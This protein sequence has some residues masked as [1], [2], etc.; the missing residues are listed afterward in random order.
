M[1][2]ARVPV[3]HLLEG[4]RLAGDDAPTRRDLALWLEEHPG[5][6]EERPTSLL[7]E[8]DKGEVR[9]GANRGSTLLLPPQ[10]FLISMWGRC[11]CPVASTQPGFASP[12]A[13]VRSPSSRHLVITL[14]ASV[15]LSFLCCLQLSGVLCRAVVLI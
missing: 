11:I 12:T 14:S 4:T 10:P 9:S 7:E 5:Y 8:A 1:T 6:A 2:D 13:T 15:F 3:I